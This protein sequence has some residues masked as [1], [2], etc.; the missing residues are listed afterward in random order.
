MFGKAS[1]NRAGLL[2]WACGVVTSTLQE[3]ARRLNFSAS[4]TMHVAQQ[5]YEGANTGERG[6]G[7][8]AGVSDAQ[9]SDAVCDQVMW[10]H[11]AAGVACQRA[12]M[13]ADPPQMCCFDC[14]C[15]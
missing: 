12:N 15:N 9:S 7:L 14:N 2:A 10:L 6:L 11:G 4:R 3:A 1:I 13:I 5:L 8:Q